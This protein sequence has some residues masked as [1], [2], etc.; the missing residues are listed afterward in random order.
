MK[1]RILYLDVIR[2][3][4]CFMILAIHAP[5]PGTGLGS[6]VLSADSFLM[7]PGLDMFV[8]VSGAL[9]LPIKEPYNIFLQKRMMKIVCPTFFWTLF[10]MVVTLFE[11]EANNINLLKSIFS[12]PFTNQFNGTF[13]YM[14]MLAGLYFLAPILSAWLKQATRQEIGFYLCLWGISLCYPIMRGF[15]GVNESYTGI[16]YYFSGYA[17]FFMLG[18]YLNNYIERI[19]VW[20]CI[21]LVMFPLSIAISMKLLT[22][23]TNFYDMFWLLSLSVAMMALAW[24][25]FIK[26]IIKSYNSASRIHRYIVIVSNCCFG[27][28]LVHIFI[29]RSIIWKWTWL[30]ELG[31]MQILLV[32]LMTFI[33][34]L[35]VTWIISYLPGAEY[36]IGF[37]Q[38]R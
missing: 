12:F 11:G 14:Y 28:Y 18:Y 4:A 37:R 25:M 2:I 34:G 20:K 16:L 8:M 35:F 5:I 3:I 15:I 36:I 33:G 22:I 17:G 27:I 31:I 9:L 32:T 10:Y 13:W 19:A 38:K 23:P 1:N 30:Y 24:F 29:M 7:A 26:G 6:Y 21:L